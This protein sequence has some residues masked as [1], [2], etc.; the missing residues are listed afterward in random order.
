MN[1]Q[2]MADFNLTWTPTPVPAHVQDGPGIGQNR[3]CRYRRHMGPSFHGGGGVAISIG[4]FRLM[5]EMG[6]ADVEGALKEVRPDSATLFISYC[7]FGLQ[8]QDVDE[9]EDETL[10]L[11]GA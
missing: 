2:A 9:M 11:K 10:E 3:T 1:E 4:M 7:S 6:I 8:T 5:E